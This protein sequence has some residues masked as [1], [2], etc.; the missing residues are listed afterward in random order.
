MSG[1]TRVKSLVLGWAQAALRQSPARAGVLGALIFPAVSA[2]TSKL[3][4]VRWAADAA[5]KGKA[6]HSNVP[7]PS[8]VNKIESVSIVASG[9]PVSCCRIQTELTELVA[10]AG[11]VATLSVRCGWLV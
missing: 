4:F 8:A 11:L 3:R 2:G 1:L 9:F 7:S 10:D 5:C 6:A